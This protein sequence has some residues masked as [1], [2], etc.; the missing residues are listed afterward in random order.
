MRTLKTGKKN[1]VLYEYRFVTG[2]KA[3]IAP[4][5]EGEEYIIILHGLDD[6]EADNNRRAQD[7]RRAWRG[8]DGEEES[9]A[10]ILSA[11]SEEEPSA[12][13]LQKERDR[14]QALLLDRLFQAAASVLSPEE[15]DALRE[16]AVR[17]R[18][19]RAMAEERG[20]S[21]SGIRW[22]VRKAVKKMGNA[23]KIK[24]I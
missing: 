11:P 19:Y 14:E 8:E 2:E 5:G 3:V 1:R 10:S 6:E 20:M 9:P 24:E 15:W 23:L 4:G 22:R 7:H 12:V 16:R 21:E 17:G 18:S 13:L